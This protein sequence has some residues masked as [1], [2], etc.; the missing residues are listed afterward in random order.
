MKRTANHVGTIITV[1]KAL[2]ILVGSAWL[3]LASHV[4]ASRFAPFTRVQIEGPYVYAPPW[5]KALGD[6][7]GDG[8]PDI[9]AG[10]GGNTRYVFWY[11][12]SSW[13]K[14]PIRAHRGGGGLQDS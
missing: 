12:P 3:A 14:H 9:A 2:L 11:Q 8:Y 13:A 7:D 10:F 1:I 6:I 4:Q 5:G